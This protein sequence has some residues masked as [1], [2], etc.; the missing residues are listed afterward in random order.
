MEAQ[1]S[2][3]DKY[4]LVLSGLLGLCVGDALGVPVEFESRARLEANP[5][6]EMRGYGTYQQSPGT[7]SD[8]SSMTFCTCEALIA[9][10]FAAPHPETLLEATATNFLKWFED[11]YWAA[12]GKAFDIGNTT[13]VA[14]T[15]FQKSRSIDNCGCTEE[16]SN[17]NGSLMRIL[18]L[19]F[20]HK[21]MD[22]MQLL[23]LTHRMSALTH[24]HPRAQMACGIYV[25]I[26][27]SLLEGVDAL[28]AY[29]VAVRQARMIYAKEPFINELPHFAMVLS[30]S[31]HQLSRQEIQ[32]TGYVIHSLEA[33]LWCLL[34]RVNYQQV[35]LQAVNLGSDTDTI[36]AIAGGLAGL[37][38]G[39]E[40]IPVEWRNA[41]ARKDDIGDLARRFAAML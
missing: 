5:V 15:R 31:I 30:G 37:Q 28:T 39:Y 20:L 40:M 4:N 18:P 29:S 3:Q 21:H 33:A 8:D 12:H 10:C 34:N 14:L 6:S 23:D 11:G 36:A 17:G 35:V 19:V 38:H 16:N 24:A 25:M 32:S 27:K 41:I 7:W 26:A 9:K 22:L 1:Q 13:L 2:R